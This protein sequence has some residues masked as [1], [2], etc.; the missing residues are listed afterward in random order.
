MSEET[1][2]RRCKDC[3]YYDDKSCDVNPDKSWFVLPDDTPACSQQYDDPDFD[4]YFS[5]RS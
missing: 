2:D 4:S 1:V 3:K 5:S